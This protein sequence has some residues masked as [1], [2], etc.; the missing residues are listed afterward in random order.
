MVKRTISLILICGAGLVCMRAADQV[1]APDRTVHGN[2]IISDHDPGVRIELPKSVQY[3]GADRW[4]LY[5]NADC[6][7]HAFVEGDQ[8]RNVRR[9]YWV[10]FEGYLASK[11]ELHHEYDS[12]RHAQIG[13]LDFYV[14]TYVRPKTAKV[15]S[16]SDREHIEAII[17]GQGYKMPAG[18]MLVRFVHL[19]DKE[20]RKEL[21]IIYGE[22][23]ASTGLSAEELQDGGRAHERWPGI[24]AD[25]V[26]RAKG[27]IILQQTGKHGKE[28]ETH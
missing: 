2:V 14:D 12:P 21:M 13:G 1:S 11:P 24:E 9:V 27:T 7:L 15:D 4:I 22:D 19:P 3:V 20:K 17:R 18:M 26:E 23:L 8:G 16:G 10:Q 5:G 28:A 6:E 25:L